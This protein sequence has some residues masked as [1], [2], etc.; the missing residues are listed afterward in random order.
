[1][2]VPKPST[3]ELAALEHPPKNVQEEIDRFFPAAIA[4]FNKTEAELH[5]LGRTLRDIEQAK[6]RELGVKHPEDV[7]GVVLQK[8][9]IPSDPELKKKAERYGLGNF[10]EG[11]RTMGH[12]INLSSG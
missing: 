5:P 10:F 8:F 3:E 9:P 12:V 7:R 4:W 2:T 1:M 6:A 11:G